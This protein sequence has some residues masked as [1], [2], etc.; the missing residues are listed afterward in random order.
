ME[1]TAY[2]TVI[3]ANRPGLWPCHGRY[4][5]KQVMPNARHSSDGEEPY[6]KQKLFQTTQTTTKLYTRPLLS[7]RILRGAVT[8]T[9]RSQM[10]RPETKEQTCRKFNKKTKPHSN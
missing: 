8:L 1:T 4:A 5:D 2:A 10:G 3:N 9:T 6:V 7:R